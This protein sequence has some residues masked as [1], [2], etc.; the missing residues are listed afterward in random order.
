MELFETKSIQAHTYSDADLLEVGEKEMQD[1][2]YLPS[3]PRP[4][5]AMCCIFIHAIV[6][7]VISWPLGR[8]TNQKS[9]C[10][11]TLARFAESGISVMN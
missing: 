10:Y 3:L 5:G 2:G 8:Q 4:V 6:K 1:K 9:P 7:A 11:Y